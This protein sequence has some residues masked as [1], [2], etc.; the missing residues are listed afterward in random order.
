MANNP[1]LEEK[2]H[3]KLEMEEIERD[4]KRLKCSIE[5]LKQE[6]LEQKIKQQEKLIALQEENKWL[7]EQIKQKKQK[8]QL[9]IL[10]TSIE[11][12]WENDDNTNFVIDK[13]GG[14][15]A[16]PQVDPQSL[17]ASAVSRLLRHY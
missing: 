1:T 17:P 14:S 11:G 16:N 15:L 13:Y 7:D 4:H 10:K 6:L 8:L 3:L 5:Q 9:Y 2:E 12:I